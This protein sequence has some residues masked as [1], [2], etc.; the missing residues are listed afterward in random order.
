MGFSGDLVLLACSPAEG[1]GAW[2]GRRV[3]GSPP[4]QR[5]R[6]A[7]ELSPEGA[8]PLRLAWSD[9]EVGADFA[10]K[11][12]GPAEKVAWETVR[13][14][15]RAEGGAAAFRDLRVVGALDRTWLREALREREAAQPPADPG[16]GP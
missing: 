8:H 2:F 10:G 11:E 15:C 6:L 14:G 12:L 13:V 5:A 16:P 4:Q 1:R 7:E 9:G 3:A